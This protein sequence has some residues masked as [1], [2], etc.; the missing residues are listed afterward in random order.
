VPDVG[1]VRI[2]ERLVKVGGQSVR[3]G[4]GEA[5]ASVTSAQRVVA[6][7]FLIAGALALALVLAA[8][9][10]AGASVSRPLRRMARIAERVDSGDLH[11]RMKADRG[12][13]EIRV[14]A[15]A[16]NHMLDRL[17]AAF[18]QQREFV[19][20]ASH[21][22]RTPLTIISGQ[23]DVLAAREQPSVDDV[24]HVQRIVAREIAR[25]TRLVD[26]MLLLAHSEQRQFA[27]RRH[28]HLPQF[29]NDLW[30]T[31]T[32]GVTRRMEAGPVPAVASKPTRTASPRLCATASKT[33]SLTRP[34]PT[35][36][37]GCTLTR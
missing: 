36:T 16:F 10:L 17:G 22:L 18:R 37:S 19:G 11:P 6:R 32:V 28:L 3:V 29:I 21:E 13:G 20:D 4:A 9:Y 2:D 26:D 27:S 5:L 7:S 25:T 14:L 35:A 24:E 12:S 1:Q 34:N 31:S 23:V 15:N 33:R 30:S 8:S